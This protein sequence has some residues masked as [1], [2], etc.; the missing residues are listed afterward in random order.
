MCNQLEF[1][2]SKIYLTEKQ[3]IDQKVA[4]VFS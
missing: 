3:V 1:T 2:D 4:K